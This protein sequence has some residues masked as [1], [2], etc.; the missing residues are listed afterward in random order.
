MYWY[1]RNF[2]GFVDRQNFQV[3][4]ITGLMTS[5]GNMAVQISLPSK[6]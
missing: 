5:L 2:K 4:A 1:W 3:N 6:I